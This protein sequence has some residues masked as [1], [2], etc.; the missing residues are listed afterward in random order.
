[1]SILGK[2]QAR[3]LIAWLERFVNRYGDEMTDSAVV[4][5]GA[6][7]EELTVLDRRS[8]DTALALALVPTGAAS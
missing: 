8:V 2:L 5:I 1:V 4:S 7:S 6:V 3:L